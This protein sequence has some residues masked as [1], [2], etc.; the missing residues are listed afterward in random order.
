MD[1]FR[2]LYSGADQQHILT[3]RA[4]GHYKELRN[5]T[6]H[7]DREM[8]EVIIFRHSQGPKLTFFRKWPDDNPLFIL[9]IPHALLITFDEILSGG[10]TM[11]RENFLNFWLGSK[12]TF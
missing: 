1:I 6:Q 9:N 7:I 8:Q 2:L 3:R 4:H 5:T 12:L 10:E 11:L